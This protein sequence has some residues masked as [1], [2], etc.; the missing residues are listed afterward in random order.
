[1]WPGVCGLCLGLLG[2]VQEHGV[3]CMGS[4][5]RLDKGNAEGQSRVV[6]G[7]PNL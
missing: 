2:D 1:M 5:F 4:H 3:S 7:S 6:S